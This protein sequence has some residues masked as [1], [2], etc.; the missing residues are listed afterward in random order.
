MATVA[1]WGR[2]RHGQSTVP[3]VLQ[4]LSLEI[5]F[6]PS[7]IIHFDKFPGS[8]RRGDTER[9]LP[10][11]VPGRRS[12]RNHPRRV[13]VRRL[14]GGW[15][16]QLSGRFRRTVD[17]D[18]GRAEDADR[19]GFVGHRLR[20]GTFARGVHQ[21]SEICALDREGDGKGV[22]LSEGVTGWSERSVNSQTE[23]K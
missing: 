18:A 10:A 9:S 17:A 11:V 3:S 6:F 4:V 15:P 5:N 14:Q 16:R 2:T 21:H 13:S 12:A 19:V 20:A 1:G 23:L 8:G 7:K 22:F